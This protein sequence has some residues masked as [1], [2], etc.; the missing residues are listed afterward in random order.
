MYVSDPEHILSAEAVDSINS[1]LYRLERAKGIET[2]V[3]MLPSIG[4]ATLSDFAYELGRRW[5]VGKKK[6][7]NGL[8]ILF[9]LD[10]RHIFF[11]TGYGL[12]GD[13]PDALCR[14]IEEQSMVPSFRHDDWNTGMVKGIKQLCGVLDGTASNTSEEDN[15]PLAPLFLM[16][17]AFLFIG[18]PI[19]GWFQNRAMKRCPNCGRHD[20]QRTG[21]ILIGREYGV[22]HEVIVYTCP[23]CHHQVKRDKKS[24]DENTRGHGFGGP[25]IGGGIIGGFGGG[26]GGGFSGGSFGGG[27]FGGGGA[28]AGF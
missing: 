4:D 27:S 12:E 9:V 5:G 25:F 19:F 6:S 7:N 15:D 1:M 21:T 11:S 24:Y 16:L 18:V 2:T 26:G 23:H 8:V 13:L 14:R 3:V 10:Q 22:K 17:F 28:G 20:L